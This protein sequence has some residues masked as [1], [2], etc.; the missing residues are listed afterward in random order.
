MRPLNLA[1]PVV[2]LLALLVLFPSEARPAQNINGKLQVFRDR[3]NSGSLL[4][5]RSNLRVEK[6]E[7]SR[8][9]KELYHRTGVPLLFSPSLLPANRRVDCQCAELSVAETLDRLLAGT[10]LDYVEV[11]GQ[12]LIES[13]PG[14]AAGANE[15][16]PAIGATS[17]A[18]STSARGA[19]LSIV[20]VA[21]LLESTLKRLGLD[22][23]RAAVA[24]IVVDSADGQPLQGA[25]ISVLGAPQGAVTNA[26]GRFRIDGLTGDRVVLTF[27][28]LGYRSVTRTVAL[29]TTDLRVALQQS[30]IELEQL[31]VTGNVLATRVREMPVSVAILTSEDIERKK[32]TRISELLRGEIPGIIAFDAGERSYAAE[33]RV[34]GSSTLGGGGQ[35]KVYVDGLE[36][37]SPLFLNL[38]NPASIDRVEIIRGPEAATLYGSD[39]LGGVLQIFTKKGSARDRPQVTAGALMRFIN[40]A[41]AVDGASGVDEHR[42]DAQVSA[43]N[44]T[45]SYNAG[46]TWGREGDWIPQ[47]SAR[48]FGFF[49]GAQAT[50]GRFSGSVT[51]RH[52]DERV[53][54]SD[55]LLPS[56]YPN[57]FAINPYDFNLF[58]GT[59]GF[60]AAYMASSNWKHAVVLGFDRTA[61]DYTQN[62]A[63]RTAADTFMV[64]SE[65]DNTKTTLAYNTSVDL[66][67]SDET[68]A[69]FLAGIDYW[70]SKSSSLSNMRVPM[71]TRGLSIP[72]SIS[73]TA[74]TLGELTNT[75]YFGQV[76]F[77]YRDA[78]HLTA[79]I[80]ADD[81][82]GFGD[83]Y[84]LAWAP[85]L[86]ATYVHNF[87]GVEVKPRIAWGTAIRPPTPGQ[88]SAR[89]TAN[90][91][92]QENL[93]LG[94]VRQKGWEGGIDVFVG[95]RYSL[96]ATYYSQRVED[97]INQVVI[98]AT[99]V[100]PVYQFQNVGAVDNTGWEFHG[101]LRLGHFRGNATYSITDSKVDQ[102]YPGYAGDLTV[103]GRVTTIP[104]NALGVSATYELLRGSATF[105]VNRIGS[106]VATD[107]RAYYRY[108]FAGDPYRG[109]LAAYSMNYDPIT[110]TNFLIEQNVATGVNLLVR[111]DNLGNNQDGEPLNIAI[112]PG[113][114]VTLGLRITY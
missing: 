38:I 110:R 25:Q 70:K 114:Q 52:N 37:A 81:S 106:W 104:E 98:N 75:G 21:R 4:Q 79:G 49:A 43:G 83:D 40:S 22:Q 44:S 3:G 111:L 89:V 71:G 59:L 86:G 101:S 1:R 54:V 65:T 16:R 112:T 102:L 105:E 76:A 77:G 15:T 103:G 17:L 47:H 107:W 68:T 55:P 72:A 10:G 45:G 64:V 29:G 74:V 33:V 92:I 11:A 18:P 27:V 8:A 69:R 35:L 62:A 5:Q 53:A 95:D 93:D 48:R 32:P 51:L 26:E 24:G 20:R 97:L 85:R 60:E 87:G 7:L 82:P 109:S 56:L 39:A 34:R 91:V 6:A 73:G 28:L 36:A 100:P 30:A 88:K 61:Y 19:S 14:T 42:Y 67:L 96:T 84:G 50:Q 94:P 46:I 41:Y 113:R 99:A 78:L 31:V 80:R 57:L 66:R 90:A 12:I 13:A 63:R 2:A 23:A 108:L 58:N 9:L